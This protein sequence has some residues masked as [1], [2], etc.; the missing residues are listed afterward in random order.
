MLVLGGTQ[1]VGRHIV[2]AALGR[3]HEVTL[4]NRGR[5]APGLFP[6][7]EELRG[8]RDGGLRPLERRTWDAVIDVNGYVPRVVRQST[9][10]LRGVVEH[11]TFVSTISVYSER[12]A[13]MDESAPLSRLADEATEEQTQETYGPLKV[14]CEEAVEE[15]FPD[16]AT[17]VR[18]GIVAGPYDE[19]DRFTYWVVRVA[20]GG[21][22]L[23][24]GTPERPVQFIDAR[25]L[26]EW[27]LKMTE[28]R[29]GG[30]YNATGPHNDLTMGNLLETCNAVAGGG[31][32]FEWVTDE[33]LL[34][35]GLQSS[36]LPLA[37]RSTQVAWFM[38]NC[39]RAIAAGLTYRPLAD[40]IR[41]TLEWVRS[42]G[43]LLEAG[44]SRQREAELLEAWRRSAQ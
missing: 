12:S 38:V 24:P 1:F 36:D 42:T 28:E 14:L 21:E 19:T 5:T 3:G 6:D 7:A 34:G 40:T 26:A 33:F 2:E 32:L 8:D 16:R 23:A 25:D 20:D 4:F 30:V 37:V 9:E 17:I 27:T 10:L 44:L 18:P 13:G 41:D 22:V 31:A 15:V 43:R 29:R 35:N 39:S 11:Y